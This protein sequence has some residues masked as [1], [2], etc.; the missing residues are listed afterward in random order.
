[1]H[2]NRLCAAVVVAAT[3]VLATAP[4]AMAQAPP[5]DSVTGDLFDNATFLFVNEIDARSGPSGENP[6]GT[7]TWHVGGGLGPTWSVSVSCLAVTGNTAVIGFS[8]TMRFFGADSPVAGLIHV[9]DGGGPASGQDSFEWA[10]TIGAPGGP[11][12]PGPSDCSSYPSSFPPSGFATGFN[13][14]AGD[15]VVVDVTPLPTSKD[16]CKNGGWRTFGVFKNQGAC[17]SFVA[18]GGKNPPAGH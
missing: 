5:G 1:M 12:I 15:I 14:T 9:V 11:P 4:S 2:T 3:I 16:Q 18:T 17:V 8:G 7:A 10:E 6:A 13:R